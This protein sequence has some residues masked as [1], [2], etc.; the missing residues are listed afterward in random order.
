MRF[1]IKT[2]KRD[3]FSKGG[4]SAPIERILNKRHCSHFSR[5]RIINEQVLSTL[6]KEYQRIDGPN[7]SRDSSNILVSQ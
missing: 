7:M 4:E 1:F 3:Q 6:F 2:T 5:I